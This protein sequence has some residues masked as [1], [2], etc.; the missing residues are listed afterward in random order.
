M[1]IDHSAETFDSS[2]LPD[3]SD[4]FPEGARM[5]GLYAAHMEARERAYRAI[6][7]PSDPPDTILS[8]GDPNLMI[9][10]PGGGVYIFPPRS[11]RTGWHYV[12]HGLAQPMEDDL[13][14]STVPDS[15]DPISGLGIE[16]VI[17]TPDKCS[18]AP[19][20]LFNLTKYMLF[21]PG[22]RAILPGHRVPCNG[23]L[24][25]GT[26]TPLRHLVGTRSSEYPS[27]IR[28]PAGYCW[29]V[30]LVGATDDEM[31]FATRWGPGT[32][33]SEIL[34]EVFLMLGVSYLS[35]PDRRSLTERT[36]FIEAWRL[37]EERLETQ[38]RSNG[39][40]GEG[41]TQ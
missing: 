17:S 28:L 34:Q 6:F 1:T 24:V 27:D 37:T 40:N 14:A 4:R 32:G 39:W 3:V 30:H 36:D 29:L 35:N 13:P 12:T 15:E 25:L 10:W 26:N 38:W 11:G 20:V 41:K 5:E 9:N 2:E 8:P 23:P 19:D 22:A 7:G 33:G 18:W 31:G 21:Q 16:L